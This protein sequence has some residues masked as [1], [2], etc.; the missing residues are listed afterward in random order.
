MLVPAAQPPCV[1]ESRLNRYQLLQRLRNDYWSRWSREYLHHLQERS[2]WRGVNKNFTVGQ[3]V[4]VRDNRYPPAKWPLGRVVET[5]PGLDGMVRVVTVRMSSTTLKRPIV[6]LS[7][8]P[9]QDSGS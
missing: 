2:K 5:H 4:V 6:D 3:L 9:G 7:P 1:P 8:L